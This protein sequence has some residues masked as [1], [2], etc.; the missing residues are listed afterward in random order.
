MKTQELNFI[1][2]FLGERG[3]E[4]EKWKKYSET[5]VFRSLQG[6]SELL[7][8]TSKKPITFRPYGSAAEDLKC[9]QPDDVGDVD[10]VIFPNSEHLIIQDELIEYLP[11][12]PLHVR[13]RGVN[14]PVL[15]SCLVEDSGFVATSALKSFHPVIFGSSVPLVVEF[16]TLGFQQP[17]SRDEFS[18]ILQSTC[19]LKN[20]SASPAVTLN[21]AQSLKDPQDLPNIYAAQWEWLAHHLCKAFGVVDTR[22]HAEILNVSSQFA[23]ELVMSVKGKSLSCVSK[24]FAIREFYCSDRGRNLRARFRDI[25]SRLRMKTER[26]EEKSSPEATMRKIDPRSV[27]AESSHEDKRARQEMSC[28]QGNFV[29]CDGRFVDKDQRYGEELVS[30]S[31]QST[32]RDSPED[33]ETGDGANG[34][35]EKKQDRDLNKEPVGPNTKEQ[36]LIQNDELMSEPLPRNPDGNKEDRQIDMEK[37]N[38]N[39]RFDHLFQTAIKTADPS[40]ETKIK[41]TDLAQLHQQVGGIDFVPALRAQGWPKV[42][43]D[44]IKRERKWPSPDVI[45][46]VVQEGFHLV[47]KSPKNGGN[48]DC[49]F[50]I[51]FSHAEYLLSQEMNDIQRE[52]YRC[53]KKYHRAYLSKEPKGLVTFHLKNILLQTIEETGVEMWSES[54]RA[55]RMMKLLENLLEALTR[56]DLRHYFVRSYNLFG[57]DYIESPEILESLARKVGQIMKNPMQFAEKLIQNQDSKDVSEVQ[58]KAQ[59]PNRELNPC[60]LLAI[61]EQGHACGRTEEAPAEGTRDAQSEPTEATHQESCRYWYRDMKDVLLAV[62][63]KLAD[64]AFND[65]D[66]SLGGLDPQESKPAQPIKID[67][68]DV[69]LD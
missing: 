64:V 48:S 51:S 68:D 65:A 54:N 26:R 14:H 2:K 37:C 47:V 16:I 41:D 12:N 38:Q 13:I 56:K 17:K 8:K 19:H 15:K 62:S 67:M 44:W 18:P 36:P 5:V 43:S 52:C 29:S 20:S 32:I 61:A 6:V 69:P 22:E 28:S 7:T 34:T 39:H 24:V 46:K 9:L 23:N 45:R 4:G 40:K 33:S 35:S 3:K 50:R 57:V 55:E 21:F 25:E 53:L 1:F 66:C 60:A 11:Q 63:K 58:S 42:A 27:T 49:D 30:I 59:V 31:S 10:I